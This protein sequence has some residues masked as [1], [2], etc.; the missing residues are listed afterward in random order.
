MRC[1]ES[2][3]VDILT[4]APCSL[5][6]P[7]VTAD[8]DGRAFWAVDRAPFEGA[9]TGAGTL[10]SITRIEKEGVI[11]SPELSYMVINGRE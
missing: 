10:V 3:I 8:W 9:A 2:G 5:K 4:D 7:T 6:K 11:E 1:V